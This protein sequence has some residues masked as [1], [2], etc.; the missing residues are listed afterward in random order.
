MEGAAQ[1]S[2]RAIL[3]PDHVRRR[4]GHLC[5]P[6]GQNAQR[7]LHD[8]ITVA[9]VHHTCL[10]VLRAARARV[11][12]PLRAVPAQD[13]GMEALPNFQPA[14]AHGGQPLASLH[15]GRA[16]DRPTTHPLHHHGGALQRLRLGARPVQRVRPGRAPPDFHV[17]P[18]ALPPPLLR[19]LR[20]RPSVRCGGPLL[21]DDA[22][23]AR[24]R[25][26]GQVHHVDFALGRGGHLGAPDP[27]LCIRTPHVRALDARGAPQVVGERH[28]ADRDDDD[29]GGVR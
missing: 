24:R 14:V 23:R 20:E 11:V 15:Q 9:P 18:D 19:K 27:S 10:F 16:H 25:L 4:V 5:R 12:L 22:D 28:L 6:H 26:S 3:L 21:L 8:P 13:Q 7:P 29:D 2:L 1:S 17:P